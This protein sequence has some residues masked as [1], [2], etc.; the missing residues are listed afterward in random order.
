MSDWVIIPLRDNRIAAEIRSGVACEKKDIEGWM[1]PNFKN[2]EYQNRFS[3]RNPVFLTQHKCYYPKRKIPILYS[4][5]PIRTDYHMVSSMSKIC[6]YRGRPR[7]G[8]WIES[9]TTLATSR[10]YVSFFWLTGRKSPDTDDR[11]CSS[12]LSSRYRQTAP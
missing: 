12:S 10:A 2:R 8:A 11:Y 7:A 5:A 4:H 6:R 3:I 1:I 9:Q